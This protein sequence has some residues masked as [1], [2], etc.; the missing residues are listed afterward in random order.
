ML[1]EKPPKGA[2]GR[3]Q[4]ND[5]RAN[6]IPYPFLYPSNGALPYP[7][8]FHPIVNNYNISANPFTRSGIDRISTIHEDYL[9][10]SVVG[11]KNTT[12]ASRRA[13]HN[14]IRNM[15]LNNLDGQEVDLGSR[16]NESLFSKVSMLEAHP[17]HYATSLSNPY[18]TNPF[19]MIV[20]RTGYPI[21]YNPDTTLVKLGRE[22]VSM[23]LRLYR[24]SNVE[25][26]YATLA[27]FPQRELN[28][29]REL[30]FYQEVRD[31]ILQK[32]ISPH[33]VMA[34][35]YFMCRSRIDYDAINR[36]RG[37]S[38]A[39]Q[40]Y[41][42]N[43]L[44]LCQGKLEEKR[45]GMVAGV[46]VTASPAVGGPFFQKG[47]VLLVDNTNKVLL[48][49]DKTTNRFREFGGDFTAT[50]NDITN[51]KK[52]VAWT[53]IRSSRYQLSFRWEDL[54]PA[55]AYDTPTYRCYVLL[56]NTPLV[57]SLI[58]DGLLLDMT[59]MTA[60]ALALITSIDPLTQIFLGAFIGGGVTIPPRASNVTVNT[61]KERSRLSFVR[62]EEGFTRTFSDQVTPQTLS[63]DSGVSLMILTESPTYN[64]MQWCSRKYDV[65]SGSI[66]KMERLGIYPDDIWYS[67][68]FQILQGS[69]TMLEKN[70][71][72]RDLN[73]AK[74]VFIKDLPVLSN[75]FWIYSIAGFD[76]YVPNKG[77]L[78][79]F[80]VGGTERTD[81]ATKVSLSDENKVEGGEFIAEVQSLFLETAFTSN[82][83]IYTNQ[84]SSEVRNRMRGINTDIGIKLGGTPGTQP[85][86]LLLQIIL[87]H[88]PMFY[89]P[90]VGYTLTPEELN[91]LSPTP[92]PSLKKGEIV[93]YLGN[94]P[95]F[96]VAPSYKWG[97]VW[98]NPAGTY[99]IYSRR[100]DGTKDSFTKPRGSIRRF[101]SSA[102]LLD[103][104]LPSGVIQ[105]TDAPRLNMEN[106]IEHYTV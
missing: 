88:L 83:S 54:D 35:G 7:N 94:V 6:M 5:Q 64:I 70:L 29:W 38:L 9:L 74:S 20:I 84:P 27:F 104:V 46:G 44:R 16:L 14:L 19:D 66:M 24:L 53:A 87:D 50:A 103:L 85:K 72:I 96:G 68:F 10:P 77:Y 12:I 11:E 86:D 99:T 48:I 30:L 67:V 3:T 93:A 101:A 61:Q 80:D 41:R 2:A 82:V 18:R 21:R 32:T 51:F 4:Y 22:N 40:N 13:I 90:K 75:Q 56:S 65:V 23:N 17:Y 15:I 98:E 89:H 31:V 34:Y 42:E 91:S 57:E 59:T 33:F 39:L 1:K 62:F 95:R 28:P 26:R 105:I 63:R 79:Q 81:F 76:F 100:S 47:G 102:K 45:R 36:A 58:D 78:V 43:Q 73:L 8:T 97:Y 71:F 92:P 60:G 55:H 106:C 25:F 69:Y 37:D 52:L 49:R